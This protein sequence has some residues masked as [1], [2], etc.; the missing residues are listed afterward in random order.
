MNII[1][2]PLNPSNMKAKNK[3]TPPKKSDKKHPSLNFVIKNTNGNIY[4][5]GK[6]I[7]TPTYA[8]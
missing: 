3:K 1:F 8:S 5:K 7:T 4:S 2:A 6:V